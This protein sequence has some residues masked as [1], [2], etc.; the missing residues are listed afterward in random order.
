[1]RTN[2]KLKKGEVI[3]KGIALFGGDKAFKI[4]LN[5]TNTTFGNRTPK[6]LMRTQRGLELV[7][8]AIEALHYGNVM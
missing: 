8:E 3:K 1:M 4:W 2:S 6:K 7:N 5:T